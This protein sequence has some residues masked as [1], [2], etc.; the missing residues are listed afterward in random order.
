MTLQITDIRL[1]SITFTGATWGTFPYTTFNAKD[2][3]AFQ[4]AG[5]LKRFPGARQN[6][7]I[8]LETQGLRAT[9]TCA[10]VAT[11]PLSMDTSST[12]PLACNTR[13]P[14]AT[15]NP[16]LRMRAGYCLSNS[17]GDMWDGHLY[18]FY[19]RFAGEYIHIDSSTGTSIPHNENITC[20]IQ[21][22]VTTEWAQFHSFD[23]ST[24]VTQR[25]AFNADQKQYP[26]AVVERI[27]DNLVN[28]MVIFGQNSVGE[29]IF[30]FDALFELTRIHYLQLCSIKNIP[31]L[32]NLLAEQFVQITTSYTNGAYQ[33]WPRVAQRQ[34][35]GMFAY[36]GLSFV[37]LRQRTH[38]RA[39]ILS[40]MLKGLILPIVAHRA[41]LSYLM[42][43]TQLAST[44]RVLAES[45][46]AASPAMDRVTVNGTLS[47]DTFAYAV[48]YPS[49]LLRELRNAAFILSQAAQNSVYVWLLTRITFSSRNNFSVLSF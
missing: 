37:F 48:D 33:S 32:D 47:H 1:G 49:Y 4:S 22:F 40:L 31:L 25:Q 12:T 8:S 15:I 24:W 11:S 21:P 44:E 14:V 45:M 36:V 6:F 34:M 18:E 35:E 28:M 2:S 38:V 43:F 41:F 39:D 42:S 17:N 5:E 3:N 20:T 29:S 7:S 23:N 19:M 30:T 27:L 46:T 26:Q 9:I 13:T 16:T 10:D